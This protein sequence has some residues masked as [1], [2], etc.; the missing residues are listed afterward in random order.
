M[1]MGLGSQ[2]G[3][4]I[5]LLPIDNLLKEQAERNYSDEAFLLNAGTSNS[6]QLDM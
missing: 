6:F 3:I 5:S 4:D 1:G 2:L